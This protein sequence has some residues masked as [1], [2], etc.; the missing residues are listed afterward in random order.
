MSESGGGT[1]ATARQRQLVERALGEWQGEVAGRVIVVTGGARGIGRS[2]CEG[3][4]R[5]GAKVV[6]ADL[7]WDDAD[8]F[9]KQLES[10]GSGMAV[11]MDITDDAALDA[12]RDAVI[13]R[14]GTVDV[15]VNNASLVSETL[16]PPTGHRNTL[17]TTDRDWEVMFGVN[18]FGTLKAIRRFIEPMR[19]QQRGA[20]SSTSSAVASWPSPAAAATTGCARG[21]SRCLTRPPRPP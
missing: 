4:L 18:V 19:A 14:F 9:R 2:L 16:F 17:D 8:D 3:L 20:A 11:D 15:L 21:R 10:D 13:D 12:A 5:A 1:V 6:A 7:T